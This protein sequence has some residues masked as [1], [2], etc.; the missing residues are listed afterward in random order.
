VYDGGVWTSA[1]IVAVETDVEIPKRNPVAEQLAEQQ[2]Q[3]PGKK[4][5]S[6]MDANECGR[7]SVGI[8]L[9]QLVR[10]ARKHAFYVLGAQDELLA[11]F[12]HT[13]LPG[14]TGPG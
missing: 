10:H 3:A 9:G 14:L 11:A 8:A 13:F 6:P 5:P 12:V 4:R 7:G 2:L 1:E